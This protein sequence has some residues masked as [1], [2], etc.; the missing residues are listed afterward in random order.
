MIYNFALWGR[1]VPEK[2]ETLA[3]PGAAMLRA[4][5]LADE[6]Q[7]PVSVWTKTDVVGV[8]YPNQLEAIRH[9]AEILGL[10]GGTK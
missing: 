5:E 8:A 3:A 4:M 7:A 9:Q 10:Q 2:T 6:C 1:T